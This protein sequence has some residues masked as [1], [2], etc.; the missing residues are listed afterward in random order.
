VK[1]RQEEMTNRFDVPMYEMTRVKG[2]HSLEH[3][4]SNL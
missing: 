1:E 4:I 3:L 2:V